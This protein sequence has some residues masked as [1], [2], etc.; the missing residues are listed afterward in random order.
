MPW[1]WTPTQQTHFCKRPLPS[2][3]SDA[4]HAYA[5][6]LRHTARSFSPLHP[7]PNLVALPQ[8]GAMACPLSI[9]AKHASVHV[10]N[11]QPETTFVRAF[12]VT[13]IG[14]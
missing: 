11:K 2:S 10:Q 7:C 3:R 8:L 6:T 1:H 13:N 9:H 5:V 14:Y 4:V 12:A